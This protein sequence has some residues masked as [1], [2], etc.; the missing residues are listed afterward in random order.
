VHGL[1][2]PD[3]FIAIAEANG[4]IHELDNWVLR[5]ACEDLGELSRHG[6]EE[7]KIAVNCS[8]LNLA[9]EELADE[10]E[11]ALHASGVAPQ[12]LEL[13][14]TENALMGNLANTL[15]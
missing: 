2:A 4:L 5:K 14:V 15:V 1:L 9:R 8:P 3:R 10:I 11:L 12:R 6:C 13:E 7:L